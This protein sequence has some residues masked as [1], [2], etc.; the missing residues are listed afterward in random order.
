MPVGILPSVNVRD[1]H[2]HSLGDPVHN[3][4]KPF[5]VHFKHDSGTRLDPM[6]CSRHLRGRYEAVSVFH[7]PKD[8]CCDGLESL[9]FATGSLPCQCF[10]K[11]DEL[12][13]DNFLHG[14]KAIAARQS[15]NLDFTLFTFKRLKKQM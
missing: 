6:A 15:H 8:P 10:A 7:M 1:Q 3:S 12:V 9:P 14:F 5:S 2:G 13:F 11:V 4:V